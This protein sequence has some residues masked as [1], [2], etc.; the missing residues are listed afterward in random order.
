MGRA[1]V[2]TPRARR[3]SW[4]C[5]LRYEQLMIAVPPQVVSRSPV[6]DQRSL[7]TVDRGTFTYVERV[8][9]PALDLRSADWLMPVWRL[10]DVPIGAVDRQ[11]D[12]V[13]Q[14]RN[15]VDHLIGPVGLM[16]G[17]GRHAPNDRSPRRD[18]RT[19]A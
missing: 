9:M 19:H 17:G 7:G 14:R 1:P 13:R 3:C 8:V 5:Q 11:A 15:K 10:G 12:Q 18:D 6:V 16:S 2:E 4:E